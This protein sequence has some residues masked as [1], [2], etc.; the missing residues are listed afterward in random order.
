M[1]LSEQKTFIFFNKDEA[2]KKVQELED[3]GYLIE[4]NIKEKIKY[5]QDYYL[6]KTKEQFDTEVEVMAQFKDQ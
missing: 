1:L 3:A 5:G 4:L 2:K 6:V